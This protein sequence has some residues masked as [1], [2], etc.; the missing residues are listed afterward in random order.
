MKRKSGEERREEIVRA[1]LDLTAEHGARDVSTQDIADRVGIAQPT[2]F[3]HFPNRDAIFR[4]ALDS[5]GRKLLDVLTPMFSGRGSADVRLRKLLA[6][7]LR[8]ISRRKGLPRLI[9]SERLHREDPE[10][11][12]VVRDIIDRYTSR[13]E[14]LLREGISQGCFRRDLQPAETAR[15]IVAMIQGLVMRW[16][17]SDFEFPL[18]QQGEVL[19]RLLEP[20]LRTPEPPPPQG[21]TRT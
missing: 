16:S 14:E 9:F 10:L 13:L 11:K 17:L 3:R 6:R 21:S 2:I 1:L 15:L 4:A 18:D 12:A 19:W 8:F 20:A 5:I 7:Q